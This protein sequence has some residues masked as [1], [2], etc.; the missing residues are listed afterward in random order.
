M[1][2]RMRIHRMSADEAM[3]FLRVPLWEVRTPRNGEEIQG[4]SA[5][6]VPAEG[7]RARRR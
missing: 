7:S 6:G 2:A 4:H 5:Q 1:Y 3:E